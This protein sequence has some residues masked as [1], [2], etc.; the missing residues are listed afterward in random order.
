MRRYLFSHENVKNEQ[1]NYDVVIV[2]G[3]LA[4]LY[5]ALCLDPKYR[6]ALIVKGEIDG[7]SS[8]L[9]QGGIAAVTQSTDCFEDHIRDTLIAGAGHCN[10]K[11]RARTCYRR[12][13]RS[14]PI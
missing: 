12:S 2:G 3:G 8:W 11:S 7:G 1:E 9:A 4:G 6:V 5:C 14:F 10:E 13:R